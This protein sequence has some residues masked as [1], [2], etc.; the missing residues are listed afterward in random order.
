MHG[1]KSCVSNCR[2]CLANRWKSNTAGITCTCPAP[3]TTSNAACSETT[4]DMVVMAATG[5]AFSTRSVGNHMR[6]RF[7]KS[8]GDW[9]ERRLSTFDRATAGPE[10]SFRDRINTAAHRLARSTVGQQGLS[11]FD[12]VLDTYIRSVERLARIEDLDVIV[13]GTTYNG[14]TIQRRVPGIKALVDRFN[15]E[16]NAAVTARHFAWVDRQALIDELPR[17]TTRP[18]QL[19]A[20]RDIHRK[21]ADALRPLIVGLGRNR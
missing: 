6:N 13:M 11:T 7:G 17:D 12:L 4:P 21:Y 14:P 16:L 2:R 8:T 10:G 20:G 15:R 1:A 5:Y 18:D 19:H 3:S 9:I